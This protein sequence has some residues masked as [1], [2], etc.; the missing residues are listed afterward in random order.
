AGGNYTKLDTSIHTLAI[1]RNGGGSWSNIKTEKPL[2][3]SCV[4]F[5]SPEEFYVTGSGGTFSYNL[6]SG[7]MMELKDREG[8]TLKYSTLRF[9]PSG[10][11]IWLADPKG[12]IALVGLDK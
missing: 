10:K 2:F 12:H 1:T 6:E 5:R 9:T 11:A 8:A 7:K 3:G 4:R